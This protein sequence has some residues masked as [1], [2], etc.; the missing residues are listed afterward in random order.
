[1]AK[2]KLGALA[3]DVRGSLAGSTFSR[4]KGGSY[5][6]QK[7][8]PVQPR[9]ALQ[10]Q[11]RSILSQV[12]KAWRNLDAA[13]RAAWD[14]WAQTHP[15]LDVFGDSLKL[16]GI[17]AYSRINAIRLTLDALPNG[18][19][20]ASALGITDDPPADPTTVPAAATALAA[21]AST[22]VVTITTGTQGGATG[23]Y[24]VFVTPGQSAGVTSFGSAYRAAI[25]GVEKSA[26]VKIE[27]TPADYNPKLG[28]VAGN[29]LSARVIRLSVDGVPIDTTRLDCIAS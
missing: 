9:T 18:N 23:M 12:S 6:R 14:A 7:V 11:Q 20:T 28:F 8:S 17:S 22:G 3:Q 25:G 13:T 10:L 26:E 27:S 5:V 1:M 29:A 24:L 19:L 2:V 15:V 21:V 4:N 16:S